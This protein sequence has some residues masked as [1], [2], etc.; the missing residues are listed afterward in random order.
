M[1]RRPR[2]PVR[3]LHSL[4]RR[5]YYSNYHRAFA[6]VY[7]D[8]Y[9]DAK[10]GTS[11]SMSTCTPHWRQMTGTSCQQS[12]HDDPTST[13]ASPNTQPTQEAPTTYSFTHAS[14]PGTSH[15]EETNRGCR[16]N[17]TNTVR[18]TTMTSPTV[19]R[20]EKRC[21]GDRTDTA[22]YSGTERE[23]DLRLLKLQYETY[24]W[25]S[26]YFDSK[27][28]HARMAYEW[29]LCEDSRQSKRGDSSRTADCPNFS[30]DLLPRRSPVSNPV[31]ER[32]NQAVPRNHEVTP[33][34]EEVL[35][36]L[37]G[38]NLRHNFSGSNEDS[39]TNVIDFTKYGSISDQESIE[40][41]DDGSDTTL[42]MAEVQVDLEALE[43]A[44]ATKYGRIDME[45][46]LDDTSSE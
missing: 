21:S 23:K 16:C 17:I 12:R 9:T 20:G 45:D 11:S 22:K 8:S 1:E 46:I 35:F 19:G 29:K 24:L 28:R 31:V 13:S 43:A 6:H 2:P 44:V 38:K 39:L 25:K 32:T 42:E 27:A 5:D 33:E 40:Q 3:P 34:K 15:F 14:T 36:T 37:S 18:R 30:A 4:P 41:V 10:Q 26:R 7:Q